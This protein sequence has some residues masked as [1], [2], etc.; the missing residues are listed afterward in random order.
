MQHIQA[1]LLGSIAAAAVFSLPVLAQSK[2]L[3]DAQVEADVLKAF[4]ADTRVSNEPINTSTVYGTVTLT[5]SV[6]NDASRDAA[7]QIA[8]HTAG[9]K[10]VVDQL[11]VG[12]PASPAIAG[13]DDDPAARNS[14]GSEGAVSAAQGSAAAASIQQAAGAGS[15]NQ[16]PYAAQQSQSGNG[17]QYSQQPSYSQQPGY[18]QQQGQ[19]GDQPAAGQQPQYSNQQGYGQQQPG[20]A[21]Q[22]QPSYGQPGYAQPQYGQGAP[23]APYG[24]PNQGYPP[25]PPQG[26]LY[27]RDYERQQATGQGA[28]AAQQYT[29]PQG[30]PAGVPVTVPNGTVLPVRINRWLSSDNAA[31]GAQFTAIVNNDVLAE[32]QI[33]IPRGATVDGT[34]MDARGSGI[35]KGR[36]ELVLQL[37]ALELGGQRYPLQS[38]LFT[39]NGRDKAAQSV[40]STIIGAGVGA[41]LGAA[42]GRGTGAAIGAGVGG[43]AGLGTAAASNTGQANLPPEALLR[44]RLTA[45]LPITTVSEGEMQR[46]GGYAGPSNA[47]RGEPGAYRRSYPVGVYAAPYPYPYY[48]RFYRGGYWY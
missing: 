4:A 16:T 12:A 10:K 15:G 42:I 28:Y 18:G 3:S 19:Y 47:Y 45:P 14:L 32:G 48:G 39:V 36:G 26:R 2:T 27:R 33:A 13:G 30:Q 29:A 38:D 11:V 22:Q 23:Q 37:N 24:A 20:Y 17:Q 25:P 5:G 1:R 8:S 41:L 21:Q 34:V 40:N 7:E 31:P 9:V 35:L 46:L 43:A 6:S 44:F